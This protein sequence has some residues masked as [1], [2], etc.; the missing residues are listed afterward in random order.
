MNRHKDR[1]K[2]RR[3]TRAEP[4]DGGFDCLPNEMLVNVLAHGGVGHNRTAFF[5]AARMVSRRWCDAVGILWPV[6]SPHTYGR[7]HR[8]LWITKPAVLRQ[9]RTKPDVMRAALD[10]AAREP[11]RAGPPLD[12]AQLRPYDYASALFETFY[13]SSGVTRAQA[14][15]ELCPGC[16]RTPT[17]CTCMCERKCCRGRSA[18]EGCAEANNHHWECDYPIECQRARALK[19]RRPSSEDSRSSIDGQ[20][21]SMRWRGRELSYWIASSNPIRARVHVASCA[22]LLLSYGVADASDITRMSCVAVIRRAHSLERHMATHPPLCAIS[23]SGTIGA[24]K[25]TMMSTP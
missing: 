22:Q 9:C 11:E 18:L 23:R 6:P 15:A 3:H 10:E 24:G 4:A 19:R 8:F 14:E 21:S 5:K 25:S 12:A 17:L 16:E 20:A 2:R 13:L 1:P 7:C